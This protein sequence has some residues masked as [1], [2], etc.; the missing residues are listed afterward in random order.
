MLQSRKNADDAYRSFKSGILQPSLNPDTI[1]DG[2]LT[3]LSELTFSIISEKV[4]DIIRVSEETIILAMRMIWE[5]MKIII[6]PSSAVALGAIMEKP[7]RFANKNVGIILSG[8]NV[9]LKNLPF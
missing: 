6:E 7:E 2:L 8:G 5:R 4:D 3:S 9:D 1:A